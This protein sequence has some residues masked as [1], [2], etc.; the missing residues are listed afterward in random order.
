VADRRPERSPLIETLRHH[1][2][3]VARLAGVCIFCAI[4][5][6][7]IFLYLVSWLQTVDGVAPARSLAVNTTSMA[8]MIPVEL[9]FGWLSDRVGRRPIL[10]PALVFAFVAAVPLFWLMHHPEATYLFVGEL[11]FVLAL[12]A[13]LGVLPAFL[14]EMT[15]PALRCTTVSLG[16]NIALGLFGGMTPLAA[17]WLV[18]RTTMDLSPAF[19]I[20]AAALVSFVFMLGFAAPATDRAPAIA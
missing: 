3:L 9:L 5:F 10:L 19:M 16:Y 1:G 18:E 12:G 7:L 17:T 14:V 11:G 2:A 8:A 6:Y 20:M 15:T 13:V 4:S